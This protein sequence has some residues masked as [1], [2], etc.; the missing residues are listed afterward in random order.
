MQL[1]LLKIYLDSPVN[2]CKISQTKEMVVHIW[3]H[4]NYNQT[5]IRY[6]FDQQQQ[7]T[8]VAVET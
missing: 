4:A 2:V 3:S 6:R 7:K 5:L 1:I 8:G